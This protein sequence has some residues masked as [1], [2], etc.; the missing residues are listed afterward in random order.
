MGVNALVSKRLAIDASLIIDLYAAPNDIR[1]SIAEEVLSWI[2]ARIVE[3]YA[4]KLLMV[5]VIGVLARYLSE[6]D[7]ELVITSFLPIKLLP[8]EIFYNEAIKV[9]RS[10]GSRAADTYYITVASIVNGILLTNDK[11][12]KQNAKK[13]SIESYYLIEEKKEAKQR[14]LQ[15]Q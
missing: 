5:E 8:E 12:Q 9:A 4:P 14:I 1:A 13:A 6:E 10:T 15:S 11:R 2:S 3:A 7:L